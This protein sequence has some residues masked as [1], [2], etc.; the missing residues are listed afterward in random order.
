[1]HIADTL[2]NYAPDLISDIVFQDE[3]IQHLK[4]NLP[5]YVTL[6][7]ELQASLHTKIIE[8]VGTTCFE[9]CNGLELND[10]IILT[11]SAQACVLVLNHDEAP[12][13]ELNK[14][15]IYPSCFE[16]SYET[17]DEAG[18]ITEHTAECE[19]ESW[20]NGTVL[21][22]W[23]AV[24]SG[25]RNIVDGDNVTLHEF[26]HQLDARDGDTDG[27]PLLPSENAYQTWAY[28]MGEHCTDFLD[29]VMHGEA[30][31]IDPYGATNPGEFFAV[32]TETF[33]EKSHQLKAKRPELYAELQAFYRL[34][35][36]SWS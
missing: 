30:T 15:L 10:E 29:R 3:W 18:N 28:V 11:I 27:V 17:I 32:A 33:F 4:T 5:L 13:P 36:T 20:E 25:A 21:L 23:D 26:A 1:M 9:G 8:F 31:V 19:G 22:A 14:I 7:L 2:K 16:T 12:Y 24:T 6:P 34:D 35:P